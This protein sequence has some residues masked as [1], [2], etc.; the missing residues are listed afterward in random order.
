MINDQTISFSRVSE[1]LLDSHKLFEKNI[2]DEIKLFV[3]ERDRWSCRG[4]NSDYDITPHHIFPRS[5]G[6]NHHPNNLI[7]LCFKCHRRIHNGL[8]T[9]RVI[10]GNYFFGGIKRWE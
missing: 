8:L 9:L 4:C 10:N 2:P 7:T 1:E 5:S 6:R 3:L